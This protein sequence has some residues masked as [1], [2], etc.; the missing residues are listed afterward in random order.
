M[1]KEVLKKFQLKRLYPG[2]PN[3]I[4][5]IIYFDKFSGY[6]IIGT[7]NSFQLEVRFVENNPEFWEKVVEKDYEILEA[8]YQNEPKIENIIS[9]R[10]KSDGEVFTVSNKIDH[11]YFLIKSFEIK[12][13]YIRAILGRSERENKVGLKLNLLKKKKEPIFTTEDGVEIFE[14]DKYW[15][16][17]KEQAATNQKPLKVYGPFIREKLLKGINLS[18]EA[19]FF[20][21]QLKAAQHLN[22]NYK[23]K[24][25]DGYVSKTET[26]YGINC[27]WEGFFE[28]GSHINSFMNK[29]KKFFKSKEKRDKY[30]SE[31]K[32]MYSKKDMLS[33]AIDITAYN[34][35][36]NTFI[37]ILNNWLKENDRN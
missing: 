28:I 34:I 7:E 25:E 36:G 27:F 4:G 20:S 18:P 29:N 26:I 2:S 35:N 16:Y 1:E 17:W 24:V 37:S 15:F 32:P 12:Q 6:Y 13:D 21:S 23:I 8:T 10:R 5:Q 14:G 9:V 31:N 3:K 33:F 30:I 19:V 11:Y 22:K